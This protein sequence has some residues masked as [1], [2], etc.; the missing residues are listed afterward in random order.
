V[1]RFW[2]GDPG[3]D[4]Q[5]EKEIF[6]FCKATIL[7]VGPP[8]PLFNWYWG[9]FPQG[10][11]LEDTLSW[12]VTLHQWNQWRIRSPSFEAMFKGQ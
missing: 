12:E 9:F 8:S 4:Y 5:Q 2:V 7:A 10:L 1:I 6:L 3:F 11:L